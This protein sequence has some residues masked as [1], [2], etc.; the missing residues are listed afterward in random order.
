VY[1]KELQGIGE[2]HREVES[3]QRRS[4]RCTYVKEVQG[5]GELD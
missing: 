5:I 1:G 2:L 3:A 4:V